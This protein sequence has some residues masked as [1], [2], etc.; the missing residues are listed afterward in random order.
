MKEKIIPLKSFINVRMVPSSVSW[1]DLNG[2]EINPMIQEGNLEP[3]KNVLDKI[4]LIALTKLL[5]EFN[6]R[7]D[8]ELPEMIGVTW[9][10]N[11]LRKGYCIHM[12]GSIPKALLWRYFEP[13]KME[14]P[15]EKGLTFGDLMFV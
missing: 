2:I 14:S 8:M 5:D 3:N 1:E 9:S 6:N 7:P 12:K 4:F 10:Q 15:Q 11:N 13:E